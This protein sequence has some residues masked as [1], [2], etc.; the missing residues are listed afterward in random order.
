MLTLPLDV[1]SSNQYNSPFRT[2]WPSQLVRSVKSEICEALDDTLKSR[3][4]DRERGEQEKTMED[5]EVDVLE[6]RGAHKK[7]LSQSRLDR[8]R[9]R[10]IEANARERNRMH[11]LNNALDSLRKVVPCYSK[12][13]KLSKIET[14]RL[15]KNYIWALSEI[16]ST[17]K[18]PEL[19]M[20]VQ[21]LC[22]GLSQPTTNLVA[23]CLQLNA[24]SLISEPSA[25]SFSVYTAY[26]HHHHHHHEP[27]VVGSSS[28]CRGR[29]L[30]PYGSL[31]D[32]NKVLYSS[33]SPDCSNSLDGGR[34][35]PPISFNGVFSLKHEEP[36]DYWSCHYALRYCS[37]S[38]GSTT[39]LSPYDIHLRGQVYQAHEELNKPLHD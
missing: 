20:F 33:P 17:G 16:L 29:P 30:R 37:I 24:H 32:P 5:R 27:E 36:V 18:R 7:K 22:K 13:Q 35:S 34:L 25:E 23:G 39:D 11:G 15:A 12:T 31:S 2:S 28:A 14:L 3:R 10:R 4:E 26:H 19:L 9:L 8:I 1:Q 21:T 38:Q 6:K